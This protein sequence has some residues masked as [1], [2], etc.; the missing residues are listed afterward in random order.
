MLANHRL[1][2]N[3]SNRYLHLP[4]CIF[5][6]QMQGCPQGQWQCDDGQ[7]IADVWRCDGSGDCLDGSDEMDCTG[8]Y[9]PLVST[10]LIHKPNYERLLP[11]VHHSFCFY[12]SLV[13]FKKTKALICSD[14]FKMLYGN[15][16][17]IHVMIFESHLIFSM[18]CLC[19]FIVVNIRE[20]SFK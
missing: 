19:S 14:S 5:V 7:C 9:I 17:Q 2:V 8:Q 16:K 18:S 1:Y 4:L 6:G 20:S 15:Q 3:E 12:V 11:F 10:T 13:N